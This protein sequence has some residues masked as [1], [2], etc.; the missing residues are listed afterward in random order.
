MG[1][2]WKPT[3]LA[4]SLCFLAGPIVYGF[5]NVAHTLSPLV[6][7]CAAS[8]I[9][10]SVTGVAVL[11]SAYVKNKMFYAFCLFAFTS[12]VDLF[13]PLELD[14]FVSGFMN[15]YLEAGEPY[16]KSAWGAIAAYWDG[17]FYLAC[18]LMMA[19]KASNGLSYRTLGLYYSANILNSMVVLLLGA[20]LSQSGVQW[21]TLLNIP[22]V[23]VPVIVGW[24]CLTE[25]R[26]K[27][28]KPR[29]AGWVK[30]LLVLL[31]I[32][33]AIAAVLRGVAGLGCNSDLFSWYRERAE[34][35]LS[36]IL[37]APFAPIQAIVSLFYFA[38]AFLLLAAGIIQ[39]PGQP[40]LQDLAILVAG[41]TLQA[42]VE[43]IGMSFHPL[44]IQQY[45]APTL[46]N[47][48]A[49]VAFWAVNILITVVPQL[50]VIIL[51]WEP[52]TEHIKQRKK[53]Q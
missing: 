16:L 5:N 35:I 11:C 38:P 20:V 19:Y 46:D 7:L 14:G 12:T 13:I 21:C 23:V 29:A 37:P 17:T 24:Q 33:A 42:E 48:M 32:E 53:K 27:M 30:T 18:Y 15:V 1:T 31:L 3:A 2:T 25:P 4:V 28:V 40:W 8:A 43:Q 9:M 49:W 36:D 44:T 45:Q 41:A 47:H 39:N 51:C 10:L 22:Y 52:H 34:P 50:T 6:I 26:K